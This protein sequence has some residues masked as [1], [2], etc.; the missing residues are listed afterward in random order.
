M[1]NYIKCNSCGAF[2]DASRTTCPNCGRPV[3]AGTT[4]PPPYPGAQQTYNPYGPKNNYT[5]QGNF[6]P[7]FLAND[8]FA[9][10]PSGSSRGVAALL[11]LFLGSM[12]VHYFYLGKTTAGIV[13]LACTLLSCGIL[14]SVTGVLGLAQG[15]YMLVISNME[16]YNK[17][18]N[19]NETFPLF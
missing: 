18:V 16:F 8:A 5:P 12:G 14:G 7:A 1:N 9:A 10:G 3:N 4:P 2:I 11:A 15:I 6:S 17:Y 13:M 19:T